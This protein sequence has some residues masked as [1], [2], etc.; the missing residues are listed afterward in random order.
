MAF[1]FIAVCNHGLSDLVANELKRKFSINAQIESLSK[2]SF[3]ASIQQVQEILLFAQGIYRVCL[4]LSKSSLTGNDPKLEIQQWIES[5]PIHEYLAIGQS[6]AVRAHR[7]GSHEFNS[8]DL[9]AWVGESIINAM[10]S[11]KNHRPIVNLTSPDILF[12]VYIIDNSLWFCL[13]AVGLDAIERNYRVYDHPAGLRSQLAFLGVL[14]SNWTTGFLFDPT[15]G[16]GTIPIEACLFKSHAPVSSHLQN[17]FLFN[18]WSFVELDDWFLYPPKDSPQS[19][20]AFGYD[21]TSRFVTYANVHSET[22]GTSSCTN[23]DQNNFLKSPT[24]PD[25]TEC[26]VY[27]PPFGVRMGKIQYIQ[28]LYNSV[29]HSSQD[30]GVPVIVQFATKKKLTQSVAESNGYSLSSLYK[31]NYGGITVHLMKFI[32]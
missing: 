2:V 15:T 30:F 20:L 1:R 7:S 5:L 3:Q 8:M 9:A 29:Y 32:L 23:F 6:F 28:R 25:G 14:L 13:D 17:K 10:Q 19:C 21:K 24:I 16:T 31:F 4:L 22:A 18:N 11:Q 12:R 26:I 27:N